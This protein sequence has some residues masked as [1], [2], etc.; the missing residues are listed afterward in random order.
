ME[1]QPKIDLVIKAIEK[2][3]AI[4]PKGQQV[5]VYLSKIINQVRLEELQNILT[6]LEDDEKILTLMRF[7]R[8]LLKLPPGYEYTDMLTGEK[9]S[10]STEYFTVVVKKKFDK[11]CE[12][13]WGKDESELETGKAKQIDLQQAVVSSSTLSQQD[14]D[15]VLAYVDSHPDDFLNRM[16][17]IGRNLKSEVLFNR[18]FPE[19][20]YEDL[21][22]FFNAPSNYNLDF[23]SML[24]QQDYNA[25]L[26]WVK[27]DPESLR[28][29][30]LKV[31]RT[32][33]TE[34]LLK[35]M[36]ASDEYITALFIPHEFENELCRLG[37]SPETES[38][39]EA[40]YPNKTP[41]EVDQVFK[42][43]DTNVPWDTKKAIYQRKALGETVKQIKRYLELHQ[44]EF[45]GIPY[46]MKT[47]N[48]VV[49]ELDRMPYVLRDKLIEE[50]P[51]CKQL[52]R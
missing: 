29:E 51:E 42:W 38:R 13:Y 1:R 46:D 3:K 23:N 2:A 18:L 49:K 39:L 6:I 12:A 45:E 52:F 43:T 11:W 41:E 8:H 34:A 40:F 4:T 15:T 27:K 20:K 35:K 9:S 32:Q 44:D 31:G 37:R 47:F 22:Q 50:S 28:N 5:K 17:S 30:F 7:P 16:R 10:P 48:K 26:L 36:R 24:S 19:I 33:D 14:L 25:A 21:D